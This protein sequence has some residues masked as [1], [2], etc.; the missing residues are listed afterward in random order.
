MSHFSILVVAD[1]ETQ[2]DAK[3]L[4]FYEYGY[5]S[6]LDVYARRFSLVAPFLEFEVTHKKEDFEKDAKAILAREYV[7]NNRELREKYQAYVD[8]GQYMRVFLDW[9]GGELG[10]NGDWGYMHN[11]NAKWDWFSVGGR[12]SGSLQLKDGCYGKNGQGGLGHP[13]NSDPGRAD[14]ALAGDVDWE[15]ILNDHETKRADGWDNW[16][17]FI[18]QETSIEKYLAMPREDKKL[19]WEHLIEM[20]DTLT[21]EFQQAYWFT[22]D[23]E[24]QIREEYIGNRR[25]L[26]FAFVDSEGKWSQRGQM[27]WWGYVSDENPDYDEMFWQFVES[28]P[29]EQKVYVV[30]CHI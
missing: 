1:N 20:N 12:W 9:N 28:L 15:G 11:P 21:D 3:L 13:A 17:S 8:E 22:F 16:A 29:A 30:D 7:Q 27:G 5:D 18:T 19:V 10:P 14:I 26:T 23:L 25:A 2:L 24:Y 4:P 6:R